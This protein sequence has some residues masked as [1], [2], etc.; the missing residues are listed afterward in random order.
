MVFNTPTMNNANPLENNARLFFI[1]IFRC[2]KLK[3]NARSRRSREAVST[4]SDTDL[5]G[6]DLFLL[7]VRFGVS[8]LLH[9][10]DKLW[11][12]MKSISLTSVHI[13]FPVKHSILALNKIDSSAY[14]CS[15]CT[16]CLP[17]QS[18]LV[19]LT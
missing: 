2:S 4:I 16:V 5:K 14:H 8:H 6:K 15:A 10:F 11:N 12:T 13:A 9:S 3:L 19:Q 7:F 17:S 18:T 1:V